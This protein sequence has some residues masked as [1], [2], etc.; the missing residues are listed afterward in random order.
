VSAVAAAPL[1][2]WD[3]NGGFHKWEHYR[4]AYE[5]AQGHWPG[6][7]DTYRVEFY[8]VDAPFARV[9]RYLD[10]ADGCCYLDP[11]TGEPAMEEVT[12]MLSELLPEHLRCFQRPVPPR[13]ITVRLNP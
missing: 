10:N 9:F 8:L 13:S 7:D 1:A 6:A 3:V 2:V 5:W 11:A 4:E 12:V